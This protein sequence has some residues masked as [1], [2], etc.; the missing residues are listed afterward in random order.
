MRLER[1]EMTQNSAATPSVRVRF[2]PSPTGFFHIG[3]ARTALF[4]WLYARHCGGTFI[5]RI[6]D[7]DKERDTEEA[8]RVLID[9]MRWLGLDWDEGPAVGGDFG[10]Y[11]QSQRGDIYRE[12]L[13]KL[14]NTGRAYE[15][16]G[17]VWFRVSGKPALIR[18]V[19]RGDVSRL[20]EKDFVIVRS[21]G[22]PVFHLVNVV[23]DIAMRITHVIRGEDHLSNSSKHVEL[24]HAF[25]Q[26]PPIFAHIP[27]ILKTV[28]SGKMS[29]RDSGSLVEEYRRRHFLPE[30]VR[31]Y[32]CL[33]GWSPKNDREIL[34]PSEM[35]QLFELSGINHNNARFDEKKLA[36]MNGE[37]VRRLPFDDFC[38][39]AMP[40]LQEAHF[41]DGD[42]AAD[43]IHS[44]LR[45]CQEKLRGLEDIGTFCAYFFSENFPRDEKSWEK[46]SRGGEP[47]ARA[48]EFLRAA[49][50]L[51]EFAAE[52]LE[53]L[54]QQLADAHG[55]KTGEYIH[56]VRYAVSGQSVGP[57]FYALLQVLGRERVCRRLEA[58][59]KST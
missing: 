36:H 24:F 4:N 8:L 23:D 40:V 28:G 6:E 59:V 3:S 17:A 9:G 18:D 58:L 44:V 49:R 7:T 19:I 15:K 51:D 20:E 5:L 21:D 30:A 10:P 48:S 14:H 42:V 38:C 39:R 1:R 32:L 22:S 37:Y 29:K 33:L 45:I 57:G 34:S 46:I 47:L 12:Y 56:A 43:Y 13:Q 26:T 50:E 16:D 25:G 52:N 27:L 41:L 55:R 2:A 53:A 54:V 31:N 11:F 35:T